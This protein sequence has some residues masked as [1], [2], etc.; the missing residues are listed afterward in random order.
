MKE[1]NTTR[2]GYPRDSIRDVLMDMGYRM[3]RKLGKGEKNA[4]SLSVDRE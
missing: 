3:V 1:K 4:P 2:Y